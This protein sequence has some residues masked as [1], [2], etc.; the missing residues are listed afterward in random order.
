M[1]IDEAIYNINKLII[2]NKINKKILTNILLII[3]SEIVINW[4]TSAIYCNEDER[5]YNS[6]KNIYS[7]INNLQ[8]LTNNTTT[9]YIMKVQ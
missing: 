3:D 1:A 5:I 9:L 2:N 7:K 4:L 8:K 6:I